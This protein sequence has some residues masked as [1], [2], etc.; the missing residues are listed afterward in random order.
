MWWP[1]TSS[2][3]TRRCST[4]AQLRPAIAGSIAIPS[5]FKPVRYAN[6]LLVDGGV[7]NPLPLDQAS[8]Q[9]HPRRHRRQWR[10]VGVAER[11]RSSGALDMWFGSAQIM[12]HSLT[13]HMMARLSARRLRA[14]ASQRVR[15]DGV[16][17]GEGNPRACRQGKGQFQAAPDA[18]R[19]SSSSCQGARRASTRAGRLG[20][21]SAREEGPSATPLTALLTDARDHLRT[22]VGVGALEQ[23]HAVIDRAGLRV[24]RRHR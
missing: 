20:R 22:M 8:G 6:H 23:P 9:R 15:R 2:P 7:V 13:A 4:R 16:L 11:A 19:S 5:L 14:P 3:G 18:A 17:A 12:M 24:R 21:A 10:S 1:P